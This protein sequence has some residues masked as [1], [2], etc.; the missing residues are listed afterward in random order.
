MYDSNDQLVNAF[1]L[2]CVAVLWGGT[3]PFIKKGSQGIEKIKH[4]NPI[5][6][7]LSELIFLF[8]NW[9]YLLPFLVNQ[10]GSVVYYITLSSAD[11]SLAVPITNSLTFIFTSLSSRL[12]GEKIP[13][14]ETCIGML[15]VMVG[16]TLCVVSK[17]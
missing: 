11:L 4:E 3:N 17:I 5:K 16:V 8:S 7:F 6:Q 12:L 9:K 2:V 15:C 13:N 1:W 10:S 14:R